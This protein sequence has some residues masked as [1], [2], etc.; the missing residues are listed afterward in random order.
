MRLHSLGYVVVLSFAVLSFLFP[1]IAL[2]LFPTDPEILATSVSSF[3]IVALGI[4]FLIPAEILLNAV[5]GTGDTAATLAV[6]VV[7]TI[8]VLGL[9]S[10][11]VFVFELPLAAVWVAEVADVVMLLT[12]VGLWLRSGR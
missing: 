10:A 12:L 6:E 1:T 8:C 3:R 11:F 7:S 5:V 9:A 4:L 2:S